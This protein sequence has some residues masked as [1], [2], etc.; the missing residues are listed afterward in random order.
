MVGVGERLAVDENQD[1][2]VVVVDDGGGSFWDGATSQASEGLIEEE[3]RD[4][5]DDD[6]DRRRRGEAL[7]AKTVKGDGAAGRRDVGSPEAEGHGNGIPPEGEDPDTSDVPEEDPAE[8]RGLAANTEVTASDSGRRKVTRGEE[9]GKELSREVALAVDP[10]TEGGLGI[11][12]A[13]V[14]EDSVD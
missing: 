5:A 11:L 4:E 7:A 8:D 10:P 14:D 12:A 1:A 6:N 9:D 3:L 2:A 13:W